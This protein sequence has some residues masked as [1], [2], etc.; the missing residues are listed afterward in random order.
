MSE[1]LT[2]SAAV[3][4][5]YTSPRRIIR[6]FKSQYVYFA[7]IIGTP[8]IK[9]GMAVSPEKRLKEIQVGC[10]C[11]I[12][13]IGWVKCNNPYDLEQYLHFEK[14]KASLL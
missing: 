9:I 7:N 5:F 13:I 8:F 4:A 1:I 14:Q 10:P 11:E 3:P 2:K 12:K 6:F